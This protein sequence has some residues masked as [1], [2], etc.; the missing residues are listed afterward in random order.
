MPNGRLYKQF[1][2]FD[3]DFLHDLDLSSSVSNHYQTLDPLT[4][5]MTDSVHIASEMDLKV[6]FLI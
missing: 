4:Q 2:S 1:S 5:I 6:I 3:I